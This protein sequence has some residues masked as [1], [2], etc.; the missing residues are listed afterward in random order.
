MLLFLIGCVNVSSLFV[1]RA[2]GR[3]QEVAVRTALGAEPG[4]LMRRHVVE[5]LLFRVSRFDLVT[6]SSVPLV[7]C[8]VT[9][10]ACA[11]PHGARRGWTRRSRCD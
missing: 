5:G 9:L 2:A 7:I 3:A 11:L 8:V 1:A 4:H 6:F 10:I